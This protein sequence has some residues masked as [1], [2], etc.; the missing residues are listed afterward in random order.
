MIS[1]TPYLYW[2]IDENNNRGLIHTTYDN[3]TSTLTRDWVNPQRLESQIKVAGL[4]VLKFLEYFKETGGEE[5]PPGEGTGTVNG[6]D[7]QTSTTNGTSSGNNKGII[8][9]LPKT[10]LIMVTVPITLIA[11]VIL[12]LRKRSH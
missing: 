7:N 9:Y 4:S 5:K 1:S 10:L 2:D 11:L 3:T 6:T 12:Y 8:H